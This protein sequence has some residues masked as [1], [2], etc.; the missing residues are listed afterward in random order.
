[1]QPF[2]LTREQA[3][4]SVCWALP[5]IPGARQVASP[6]LDSATRRHREYPE[7]SY[8]AIQGRSQLLFIV[9][10]ESNTTAQ[11][12]YAGLSS[13][14]IRHGC[15]WRCR[16]EPTCLQQRTMTTMEPGRRGH[17][18]HLPSRSPFRF[19]ASSPPGRPPGDLDDSRFSTYT[20]FFPLA[21]GGTLSKERL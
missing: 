2:L 19:C 17:R 15:A 3:F 4:D 8:R 1:M 16:P 21:C 20:P 12:A 14:P 10:A 18:A 9:P 11:R 5:T 7:P 6:I 13:A